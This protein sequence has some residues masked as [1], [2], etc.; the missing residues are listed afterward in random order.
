[1]DFLFIMEYLRQPLKGY[2]KL[3]EIDTLGNVF[4]L[5]KIKIN[6]SNI[7]LSSRKDNNGYVM[8]DIGGKRARL[9]RLIG[10]QFIPNP[11]NYPF[12]N[13]I[14]GIKDDNRIEN[15][16]WCTCAMNNKHA[17]DIGLVNVLGSNHGRSKLNE[18]IVLEIRR[19]KK[20]LNYT[21]TKISKIYNVCQP[22]IS[23]IVNRKKWTHI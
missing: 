13:H 4:S 6:K 15:L 3:Y 10:K 19:L 23:L 7:K 17:K 5:F 1:M 20:E 9:H 2:E 12:I 8:V 16:E 11:N 14:N 21:N 18:E 22:T